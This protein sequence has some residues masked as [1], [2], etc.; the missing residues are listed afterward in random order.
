MACS[1]LLQN[2]PFHPF[3]EFAKRL[4][5]QQQ[6]APDGRYIARHSQP[7][8]AP[9]DWSLHNQ[10]HWLLR[11]WNSTTSENIHR[12]RQRPRSGGAD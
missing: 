4:L 5:E 6:P 2:T 3:V 8:I 10:C 11:S 1:Q 9:S 7:G 12:R